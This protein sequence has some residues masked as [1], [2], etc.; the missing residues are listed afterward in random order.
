MI[1]PAS[2]SGPGTA[3]IRPV[4]RLRALCTEDHLYKQPKGVKFLTER[5]RYTQRHK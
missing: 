5:P 3:A 4:L 1:P 2:E